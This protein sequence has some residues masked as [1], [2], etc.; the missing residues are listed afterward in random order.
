[1]RRDSLLYKIEPENKFDCAR[2]LLRNLLLP[3]VAL[4]LGSLVVEPV[5]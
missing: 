4:E 3:S 1:M 5:S 2:V